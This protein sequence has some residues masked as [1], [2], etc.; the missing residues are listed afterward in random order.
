MVVGL[1]AVLSAIDPGARRASGTAALAGAATMA[2]LLVK[3]NMADVAVFACV[4]LLVARR[5][6]EMTTSR[7]VC[8]CVGVTVGALACLGVVALWT[9]AHGTSPAGVFDAMYPFRIEAGRV[10][11]ASN[12]TAADERLWMLL[13]SWVVSG[14][15]IIMLVATQALRS[16]RLR[17]TAVWGLVATVLFDIVSIA[18]GGSYWDHYLLQ[19]VV[20]MAVLSGLLVAQRQAGARIVLGATSLAAVV[21]LS[22]YL[23]YAHTTAGTSVGEA[24]G[25]VSGP[26]DTIVTT[27]GH[28]DV[29]R[30][31]GLTSP[32]PYLWSLPARTLDPHRTQLDTLLAG[33]NAPTWFVTWTRVETWSTH[34]GPATTQMLAA[35]Y[36]PVA[37]V[38][39]HTI[40][41]HR[42]VTRQAPDL[43]SPATDLSASSFSSL[44][45]DLA[46]ELP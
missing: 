35:H 39:G 14:G 6:G 9:M 43:G 25:R 28:A 22:I 8:V 27:W 36:D 26:H 20:P 13:V 4:T 11:A 1:A 30:A 45:R 24:I 29:T 46:A 10:M 41:L 40:Y 5:R 2:S 44:T 19:L 21:T 18:L 23:G 38:D 37:Q 15:G 31:S 33:P 12:R 34:Q 7:L 32:Y 17:S 3:Q 16:R 42:H